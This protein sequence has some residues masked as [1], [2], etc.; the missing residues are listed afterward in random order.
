MPPLTDP[1]VEDTIDMAKSA[2]SGRLN[3]YRTEVLAATLVLDFT[4]PS[5][6]GVDPG[7]AAR[8]VTLEGVADADPALNGLF[9]E[10]INL[11]DAAEALTVKSFSGGTVG[12]ISQNEKARFYHDAVLALDGTITGSGWTLLDITTIA[13]S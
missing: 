6:I 1:A 12:T 11:A 8:D 3:G 5:L 7:G 13:L 4:Y 10:I 9:V 2:R